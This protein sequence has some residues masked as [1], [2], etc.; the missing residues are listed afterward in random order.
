MVKEKANLLGTENDERPR[1]WIASLL[2]TYFLFLYAAVFVM[3]SISLGYF[4]V[5]DYTVGS[6]YNDTNGTNRYCILYA[7]ISRDGFEFGNSQACAV[8]LYGEGLLAFLSLLLV[9]VSLIKAIWGRW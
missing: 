9:I 8:T 1:S 6:Y 4:A 7:E 2:S 3:T 5:T